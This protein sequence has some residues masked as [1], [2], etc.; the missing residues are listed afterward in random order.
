[1]PYALCDFKGGMTT[2]SIQALFELTKLGGKQNHLKKHGVGLVYS[3]WTWLPSLSDQFAKTGGRFFDSGNG[4]VIRLM[5][6]LRMSYEES[7]AKTFPFDKM[8]EGMMNPQMIEA[9]SG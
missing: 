4:G 3:H 5:T 9:R 2:G 6:P 8:V 1:M 7:Y